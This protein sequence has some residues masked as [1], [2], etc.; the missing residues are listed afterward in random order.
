MASEGGVASVSLCDA[1]VASLST[2]VMEV[3]PLCQ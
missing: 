2:S 3:W 1:G